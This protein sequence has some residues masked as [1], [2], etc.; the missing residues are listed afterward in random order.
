MSAAGYQITFETI[1]TA[2]LGE[3]MTVEVAAPAAVTGSLSV[4]SRLLRPAVGSP[5][6]IT[7]MRT[8]LREGTATHER[9]SAGDVTVKYA[10]GTW[11]ILGIVTITESETTT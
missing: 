9:D 8:A 3:G 4:A 5:N 10:D 6:V 2:S 7:L 11:T 1:R